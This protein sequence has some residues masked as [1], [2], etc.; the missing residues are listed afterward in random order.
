[1]NSTENSNTV[2]ASIAMT[3]SS[4][5]ELSTNMTHGNQNSSGNNANNDK[6]NNR[7]KRYD[8]YTVSVAKEYK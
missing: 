4:N 5:D 7:D 6:R 3:R 2:G 1:M 8:T